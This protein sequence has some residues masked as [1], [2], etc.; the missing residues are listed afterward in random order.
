MLPYDPMKGISPPPPFLR[1]P[2][3][4]LTAPKNRYQGGQGSPLGFSAWT[5]MTSIRIGEFC[6]PWTGER[7]GEEPGVSPYVRQLLFCPTTGQCPPH[8]LLTH[9]PNLL[10]FQTASQFSLV[11]TI[12]PFKTNCTDKVSNQPSPLIFPPL[13]SPIMSCNA[14]LHNL[15]KDVN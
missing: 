15:T 11:P 14:S 5:P 2:P 10:W 4:T 13:L 3:G 8:P 1:H 9:R 7:G 12:S 6:I